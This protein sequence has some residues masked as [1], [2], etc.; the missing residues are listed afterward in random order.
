MNPGLYGSISNLYRY[1]SFFDAEYTASFNSSPVTSYRVINIPSI[2][3][4]NAILS[5]SITASDHD[6]AGDAR[7]YYDNGRGGIY[8][9]S[10]SGTIVGN[11]FY[12]EG[13]IVFKDPNLG[14]FGASTTSNFSWSLDFRGTHTIPT[15]IFK[16]RARAGELD[17]SRNKTFY[18]TPTEA[19][20]STRNQRTLHFTESF[21]YITVIGLFNEDYE[22]VGT[23]HLA[24]PVKKD[25][26][27]DILFRVRLD[28]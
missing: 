17:A 28:F 13:L 27:N 9:G 8:S 20:S 5:G 12:S 10:V 18:H 21:T 15:K 23:A 25:L 7:Y 4:D 11:V 2:Y 14:D 3:Y 22:L 1:Y 24:Q 19:S 26:E 6:S 16:C